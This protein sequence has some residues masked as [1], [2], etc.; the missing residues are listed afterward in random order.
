MSMK[1]LVCVA[2]V[3]AFSATTV[4]HS[5][6]RFAGSTLGV[7]PDKTIKKYDQN[8]DFIWF[9]S[10]N[11]AGGYQVYSDCRALGSKKTSVNGTL[12]ISNLNLRGFENE[13][14]I[15]GP[16]LQVKVTKGIGATVVDAAFGPHVNQAGVIVTAEANWKGK[17]KAGVVVLCEV[18]IVEFK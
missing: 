18:N 6:T 4:A 14:D 7:Q 10:F 16:D 13:T 3:V 8:L 1:R 15:A 17:I 5:E 12:T 2:I 11:P 9:P